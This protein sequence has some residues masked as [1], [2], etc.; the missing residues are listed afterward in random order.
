MELGMAMSVYQDRYILFA[1]K[2]EDRFICNA[3]SGRKHVLGR[4]AIRPDVKLWMPVEQT[5]SRRVC[6]YI[7]LYDQRTSTLLWSAIPKV[8]SS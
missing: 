5:L 4:A 7:F 2:Y 3:I 1:L 6:R 8:N